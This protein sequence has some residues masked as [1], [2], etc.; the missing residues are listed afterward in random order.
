[1]N[2]S[3]QYSK[4]PKVRLLELNDFLEYYHHFNGVTVDDFW[5]EKTVPDDT[6]LYFKFTPSLLVA[7][8]FTSHLTN[9][10]TN[11]A[12]N[13][14]CI[15][16]ANRDGVTEYE[17]FDKQ[18]ADLTEER[19][20]YRKSK[21]RE[22]IENKILSLE[23]VKNLL[24]D[25][26]PTEQPVSK[27]NESYL[28]QT[29]Y[30]TSI[31]SLKNKYLVFDVET[32]GLRKANDDLLSLSIYDPTTGM[33]YNRFFP[34]DLQPI[35]LT[36]YINGI[37]DASLVGATHMTQEEFDWLCAYF[38]LK[39][40]ILL[41]Y[42][43]GKGTFDF[44]FLKNYCIRHGILGF[45][46]L[47]T[48]NIK[49]RIPCA[50]YGSEGSLSKDN[51]CRLFGISGVEQYHT[52]YN[53][54]ILEWKLFEK[55]ESECVFFI[56]QYLYKYTPEYIIPVS[57][58]TKY[59]E[60]VKYAGIH[61]PMLRGSVTE[62]FRLEFPKSLLREIQKFPTNIT[63]LTIEHGINTYLNV[64]K[65]N[66][67]S[68][69][70]Q[71]RSHLK[72]VGSLDSRIKQIPVL[73]EIDGTMRAVNRKDEA[74]VNEVNTVTK[75]IISHIAPV[76]AFLK[77]RIFL[78]GRI[79]SQELSISDDGKVLALCDLSDSKNVVEIKTRNVLAGNG[80]LKDEIAKQLYYQAKGRN[81]YVLSVKFE[82]HFSD[83]PFKLE[84][85]DLFVIL[86]KVDLAI[87]EPPEALENA[88]NQPLNSVGST[89]AS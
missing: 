49:S 38:H 45:T 35:I 76:A 62:V 32:N 22:E 34:L 20:K 10:G 1:M 75:L 85:D 46:K 26:M 65:Q 66:H 21:K 8:C 71:N 16:V 7:F 54:C 17:A 36:G 82:T 69:L 28:F 19:G 53:D 3:L 55:L 89:P 13:L 33:C 11:K 41:S 83:R 27:S 6:T 47:Q 61:V 40:R 64:D 78:E 73:S 57:Y 15:D 37:T 80:F 58:L 4:D 59:P 86:Y 42:S 23:Q 70:A 5:R 79:M 51:M 9:Y 60:L 39:D 2:K 77:E 56:D 25:F 63:G 68:F 18:I 44:S 30:K 50:P 52:S 67:H 43:G 72:Y 14:L 48:A 81:T 74:Y 84:V 12:I 87:Q 24:P 29:N 31:D 88:E